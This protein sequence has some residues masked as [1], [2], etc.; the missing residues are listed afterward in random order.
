MLH[1]VAGL[2]TLPK[3]SDKDHQANRIKSRG[4]HIG[5]GQDVISRVADAIR[6]L[7]WVLAVRTSFS[8]TFR[9][10]EVLGPFLLDLAKG[11]LQEGPCFDLFCSGMGGTQ[12]ALWR[13]ERVPSSLAHGANERRCEIGEPT[14]GIG[15]F[16]KSRGP[17][18]DP[19]IVR[20]LLQGRPQQGPSNLQK[21]PCGSC[22]P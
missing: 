1:G 15:G 11:K 14:K 18:I 3:S 9:R 10:K 22:R 7:S 8:V 21:Q 5:C 19:K 12:V 16:E 4:C 6:V 2:F 13:L 17:I 20:L